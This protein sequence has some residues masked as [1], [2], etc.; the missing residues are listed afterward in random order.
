MATKKAKPPVTSDGG[1]AAAATKST[2]D[3]N[4]TTIVTIVVTVLACCWIQGAAMESILSMDPR[5]GPLLTFVQFVSIAV[6]TFPTSTHIAVPLVYHGGL[7]LLYFVSSRA[8][9]LAHSC[10]LSFPLLNLF[11][12]STPMASLAT[13]YLVFGKAYAR[14]QFLGVLFISVGIGTCSYMDPSSST[15]TSTRATFCTD[16]MLSSSLVCSY[17]I[18]QSTLA[19][20]GHWRVGIA[21][22]LVGL[23]VGSILGHVQNHVMRAHAA[24]GQPHPAEESMFFM[25]AFALI[26]MA[27]GDGQDLRTTW[28]SWTY[29]H[30][31]RQ[32]DKL[33]TLVGLVLL[34][35]VTNYVCIRSVYRLASVVSTVSLQVVLTLRKAAS[36]VFSVFYF[37]QPFSTGQWIGTAVVFLGAFVYANTFNPRRR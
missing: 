23:V 19:Q 37:G 24:P 7:S 20:V 14:H 9:S 27:F 3:A 2:D 6:M 26:L 22:L 29:L 1:G 30:A 28:T 10:G 12:A 34:N 16:S 25:H 18:V 35:L 31:D 36:L 13:G 4:T 8:N 17:P 33:W 21:L 15:S 32:S 5:S 11:R